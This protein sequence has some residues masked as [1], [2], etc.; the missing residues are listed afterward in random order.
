MRLAIQI[1]VLAGTMFPLEKALNTPHT[2]EW[3][4]SD[5]G[6]WN[7]NTLLLCCFLWIGLFMATLIEF[8]GKQMDKGDN[9][10]SVR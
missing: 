6:F 7:Y 3:E 5:A 10:G 1:L 2:L 9:D 8:V 4:L